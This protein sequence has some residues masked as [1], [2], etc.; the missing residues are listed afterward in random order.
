MTGPLDA[1]LAFHNAFR[2]DIGL[3]DEAAVGL[4]R[5][6]PGLEP[7]FERYRF[8]NEMLAWHALGEEL[9]VFPALDRVAPLVSEPY[10]TDHRGLDK[11]SDALSA[12]AGDKLETARVAA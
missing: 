12:A 5:A 6:K 9:A 1:V 11:L 10:L 3:I 4:A 2:R 8:F 7:Q